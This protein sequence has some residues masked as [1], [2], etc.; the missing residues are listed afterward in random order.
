MNKLSGMTTRLSPLL[1]LLGRWEARDLAPLISLAVLVV[2]F[3]IA[4][5]TFLRLET[6]VAILKEGSV[7][8]IAAAHRS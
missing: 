6:L 1:R 2:F 8:A 4:T 3:S 5:D 7:Y